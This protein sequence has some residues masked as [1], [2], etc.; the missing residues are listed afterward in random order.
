MT[1]LLALWTL[2][3][4]LQDGTVRGTVELGHRAPP[5]RTL[6][7]GADPRVARAHPGG[8]LDESL[9]VD[10]DNGLKWA[11]VSVKRGLEGRTF[12]PPATPVLL[13]FD[14]GIM[15]P[16]VLGIQPGQDLLVRTRDN[17]LHN[18]HS[19]PSE[20]ANREFNFGLPSAGLQERKRFASPE[21]MMKIKCD[22]HPCDVA[23]A[24]VV[25]HPFFGVTDERGRYEIRGLPR[26]RYTLEVRHEMCLPV[27]REVE[28]RAGV[29]AEADFLV[30]MR[31]GP[32]PRNW[33]PFLI[34][35]G[36]F[37]ATLGVLGFLL[38]HRPR[39]TPPLDSGFRIPD[40]S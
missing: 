38:L 11:F 32:P 40:S 31:D 19:L 34:A 27:E 25:S 2:A 15:R 1:G 5:P 13:E 9:A 33:K 6:N 21:A 10:A 29:A 23:W 17:F 26:G 7:V 8:L 24:N 4:G 16:R 28:V 18:C 3:A 39:R 30:A 14:G 12:P 36:A 20:E 22:V 37:A 35:G